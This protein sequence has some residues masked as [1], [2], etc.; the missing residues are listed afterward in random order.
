[1]FLI[2][3]PK[4]WD[5]VRK[6][7]IICYYC[8]ID[9]NYKAFKAKKHA[10]MSNYLIF[11]LIVMD[12]LDSP[13]V[14]KQRNPQALPISTI[15]PIGYFFTNEIPKLGQ[16]FLMAFPFFRFR[17]IFFLCH[18][19]PRDDPFNGV[20]CLFISMTA[21]LK[22]ILTQILALT[23]L[24][25]GRQSF[26]SWYLLKDSFETHKWLFQYIYIN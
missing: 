8:I 25:N 17:T 24:I 23:Q 20:P 9:Y 3:T 12:S 19:S 13:I 21:G 16:M 15:L 10:K 22:R 14:Y 6:I 5:I 2:Y 18:S 11:S 7:W 26:P 1:M 4:I